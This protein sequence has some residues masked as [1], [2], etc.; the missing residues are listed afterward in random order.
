M[1][2]FEADF[3]ASLNELRNRKSSLLQS[4]KDLNSSKEQEIKE[5]IQ[6]IEE[7]YASL[8]RK[9][10]DK[11][12]TM[13]IEAYNYCNLIEKYSILNRED[14]SIVLSELI[15]TFEGKTYVPS[16]LLYHVDGESHAAFWNI[17]MIIPKDIIEKIKD[18]RRVQGR[19]INHLL[20]NGLAIKLCDEWSQSKWPNELS[21][22]KTDGMCRVNQNISFKWFTYVKCF[23]DFVINY[24]IANKI[25]EI[26]F[27]E[28]EKLK[29]QFILMNIDTIENRYKTLSDI[30][31]NRSNEIINDDYKHKQ[32]LLKRLVNEIENKQN[33]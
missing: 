9:Y 8:N 22:Y 20:K 31:Q 2:V 24:R 5:A 33:N 17:F 15:S 27:E 6:K 12:E 16:S 21:F 10:E 30:E 11:F 23:I 29:E 14:I 13:Y 26:S 4:I 7:K 3:K 32:K 1:E 25:D 18:P 19:Y 28:L